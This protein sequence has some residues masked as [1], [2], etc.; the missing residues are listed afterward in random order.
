MHQSGCHNHGELTDQGTAR[1]PSP[2]QGTTTPI[3]LDE[4]SP[5][6]FVGVEAPPAK[7]PHAGTSVPTGAE[8]RQAGGDQPTTT[9]HQTPQTITN[10]RIST[11]QPMEVDP[12][13][14]PSRTSTPT[15]PLPRPEDQ[16]TSWCLT[17]PNVPP[18]PSNPGTA[19]PPDHPNQVKQSATT[20]TRQVP[21]EFPS[22]W[23]TLLHSWTAN[24]PTTY[25]WTPP[26]PSPLSTIQRTQN[27]PSTY[28]ATLPHP[29]FCRLLNTP[30]IPPATLHAIHQLTPIHYHVFCDDLHIFSQPYS[31]F[32][33]TPWPPPEYNYHHPHHPLPAIQNTFLAT[34]TTNN[35]RQRAPEHNLTHHCQLLRN[36]LQST[37]TPLTGW[38]LLPTFDPVIPT[39]ATPIFDFRTAFQQL[40]PYV[41]YIYSLQQFQPLQIHSS[42]GQLHLS[43]SQSHSLHKYLLLHVSSTHT[44]SYDPQSAPPPLPG[45]ESHS[46]PQI[47]QHLNHPSPNPTSYLRIDVSEDLLLDVTADD[48]SLAH[49]AFYQLINRTALP[50]DTTTFS[51]RSAQYPRHTIHQRVSPQPKFYRF[52]IELPHTQA[53]PLAYKLQQLF[54]R[55]SHQLYAFP[56]YLAQHPRTLLLSASRSLSAKLT[57][58]YDLVD[59]LYSI[60]PFA[61]TTHFI[62]PRTNYSY[63]VHFLNTPA[64]PLDLPELLSAFR[65]RS[66]TSISSITLRYASLSLNQAQP[67]PHTPDPAP[68]P[69]PPAASLIH[70]GPDV[71]LHDIHSFAS[72]F[73][74]FTTLTPTPHT[75]TPQTTFPSR[76]FTVT[77][78]HPLSAQLSHHKSLPGLRCTSH[79]PSPQLLQAFASLLLHL[80][81]SHLPHD[82]H[83]TLA[84]GVW[85]GSKF[86]LRTP[87]TLLQLPTDP[88]SPCPP[89]YTLYTNLPSPLLHQLTTSLQPH[90]PQHSTQAFPEL[91]HHLLPDSASRPYQVTPY[92]VDGLLPISPSMAA[93]ASLFLLIQGAGTLRSPLEA[94]AQA[95]TAHQAFGFQERLQ[96]PAIF[97]SQ[98][99][100]TLLHL[101]LLPP[102]AGAPPG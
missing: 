97:C 78:A 92:Q 31:H 94:Q 11:P 79:P 65:R 77:Y 91:Y 68:M 42:S 30:L 69:L 4:T 32:M 71:S 36:L 16:D 87:T 1:A 22:D 8:L 55:T 76:Q 82:L 47:L 66:I 84:L 74:A 72:L 54:P 41:R 39:S 18:E 88:P 26:S 37:P 40:S 24:P 86:Q 96:E 14:L 62:I 3:D 51:S 29:H 57:D 6:E 98:C 23:G 17:S 52:D 10:P 64:H 95:I 12:F 2:A 99:P 44:Y 100:T 21:T 90:F 53:F 27:L 46:L 49:Q 101:E 89:T 28:Q 93:P 58:L 48:K 70:A 45:T 63:L 34:P 20:A 35:N 9:H 25:S 59:T 83:T 80:P 19:P 61:H 56:L 60:E 102:P 81:P 43:Y 85:L 13:A 38:I 7:R 73:G 50:P 5:R 33:P 75:T 15:T 67:T